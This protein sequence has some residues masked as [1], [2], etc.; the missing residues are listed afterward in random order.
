MQSVTPL[1]RAVA[2]NTNFFGVDLGMFLGPFLGGI[3]YKFSDY[4]VMYLSTIAPILLAM[5][6]LAVFWPG[7][8]R[9]RQLV[10]AEMAKQSG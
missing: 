5:I 9:R 8:V 7:Y 4:S 3:I 1:K 10:Q 2:S 6:L